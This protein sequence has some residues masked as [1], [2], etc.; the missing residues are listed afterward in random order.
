MVLIAHIS[1]THLGKQQY[2]LEFRENDVYELFR[3]AIDISIKEHVDLVIISGDLFDEYRPRIAALKTAIEEF[4][5]LYNHSIPV[6]LTP[7][8]HDIPKKR[9]KIILEVLADIVPNVYFLGYIGP[10]KKPVSQK[11]F[12]GKKISVYALPFFPPKRELKHVLV[13]FINEA[14]RFFNKYNEYKHII[15]GHY[16][17][18]EFHPFD[19]VL[20]LSSL[21]KVDYAAFGHIHDRVKAYLPKGGIFSY[22]GSI[23]IYR[24]SEIDSWLKHGKGFN[25]V[26]LSKEPSLDSIHYV[27]LDVRPQ[28]RYEIEFKDIDKIIDDIR[29]RLTAS[30]KKPIVVHVDVKVP[31]GHTV[32]PRQK[33]VSLFNDREVYFR[34]H[35]SVV[36]QEVE[37]TYDVKTLDED[38]ILAK[39]LNAPIDVAREILDLVDK[40]SERNYTREELFNILESIYDKWFKNIRSS[41]QKPEP[42]RKPALKFTKKKGKDLLEYFK[43]G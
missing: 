11:V 43:V 36:S 6:I 20:T 27:N 2:G 13:R 7:G 37:M 26:D 34:I 4:R 18:Y 35:V 15:I 9:D 8:D 32:N 23:D 17:V 41:I 12:D 29:N 25:I 22:P 40:L 19:H 42:T 31:S 38:E 28:Y 30:K 14:E 3:Q 1:D 39:Y 16:S 21:P 33:L 10:D 5:R 24:V